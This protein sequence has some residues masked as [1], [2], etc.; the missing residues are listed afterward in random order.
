M[1]SIRV[2]IN[3]WFWNRPDVG[4]GQY[5]RWLVWGLLQSEAQLAITLVA[6]QSLF[7][8]PAADNL[9]LLVKPTPF[10]DQT[11][12]LA[13]LWFEQ[14]TF[15]NICRE[16]GPDVVHV[17]YYGAPFRSVK[18]LVVTVHDLIPLIL[19]EY[20][21]EPLLRLYGRLLAAVLP[22][23]DLII[24]PSQASGRDIH[25]HLQIP[26][27]QIRVI[28]EA[29]A[30]IFERCQAPAFCECLKCLAPDRLQKKYNLPPRYILYVGGYEKRKNVETLINAFHQARPHLPP[31]TGL[32]LAGKLPQKPTAFQSDPRPLIGRLQLEEHIMTPGWI[33]AADL[34]ELY[35][36]ADLFVYPSRYEGFGLPVLEAMACGTAVLTTT[37]A[38]L[39]EIAG[40]AAALVAPDDIDGMA[41]RIVHLCTDREANRCLV[42]QGLNH[43]KQFSWKKTA[44]ETIRAY[45]DTL[46]LPAKDG[47]INYSQIH[48]F[49]N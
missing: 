43:V 22:Q 39:P 45:Q 12:P 18:P 4:L 14:V 49:S 9:N 23:A 25:R 2:V 30:P 37:A 38:S 13:R 40:S 41:E 21:R 33:P 1:S 16:L 26:C 28:Y 34:P 32:V 17:P 35:R 20:G 47:K 19:P 7:G 11:S 10:L 48:K 8:R 42:Q 15:P 44:E 46:K 36:T 3:G 29:P 27:R 6:P 31:G 24:A 5:I